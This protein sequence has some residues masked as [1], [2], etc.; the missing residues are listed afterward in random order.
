MHW[1]GLLFLVC[2]SW[3]RVYDGWKKNQHKAA[4]YNMSL[5]ESSL[6]GFMEHGFQS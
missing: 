2:S 6:E 5:V 1:G 4:V 3:P